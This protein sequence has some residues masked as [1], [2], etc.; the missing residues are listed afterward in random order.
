MR[1]SE[2]RRRRLASQ[3]LVSEDAGADAASTVRGLLALQAQD[4]E[5]SLWA[6]GVRTPGIE[7][8]GVLAAL[9][10]GSVVR[11]WPQ[12]GT[13][14]LVA[15]E[16]LG[17]MLALT[18]DR[19]ARTAA[20]R[21]RA[22]ELTETDLAGAEDAATA[23]LSGGRRLDRA[24][25]LSALVDGG[26][27]IRGQR[28]VHLIGHVANRGV[29]C[30]GPSAGTAQAA[31][32][33]REWIRSPRRLEG[34]E[35]LAE[36]VVRY[37]AGHGPATVADA[38]WWSGLTLG[39]VRRGVAAAGDRVEALGDDLLVA[40]GSPATK[41]LPPLSH[42]VLALP[43]F[44]EYL[45]GYTDRAASIEVEHFP[46]AVPGANGVFFPTV[47]ARGR[48]VATWRRARDAGGVSA[49]MTPFEPA[50]RTL[51]DGFRAAM[52]PYGRFLGCDIRVDRGVP[53]A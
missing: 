2:L 48:I 40:A 16:D 46:R 41:T 24:G 22:L 29:I 44:D 17:W 35:A 6:V 13:L 12:R 34:D 36:Y 42:R 53:A 30:W 23:A 8:P 18:A 27:D 9:D 37:L 4:F 39:S 11:S 26:L 15:A 38:A 31:V 19:M 1:L 25:L 7:R 21:H 52:R 51:V 49:R 10:D 14:H 50:P 20:G 28:G 45:L 32:L 43:A 5:A 3:L 47:V 33:S